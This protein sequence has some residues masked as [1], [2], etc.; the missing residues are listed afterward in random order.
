MAQSSLVFVSG[1]VR[2]GKSSFAE[3][4]AINLAN[5]Q[6]GTLYYIA[7]GR[8]GDPEMQERIAQHKSDRENGAGNWITLEYP[9]AI[10]AAVPL[11]DSNS[12]VLLDCLTTLLNNEMFPSASNMD[13]WE[14][15]AFLASLRKRLLDAIKEISKHAA[16][17][18]VVSN[19]VLHAPVIAKGVNQT[20]SKMI[21]SLHQ[22]MVAMSD[23]AYLME[24]GCAVLMK[25][26]VE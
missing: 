6:N 12:I 21:G 15:P 5:H 16:S 24:A 22:E 19:E 1:G 2:S 14:D 25:G 11:L 23:T 4:L 8:P 13:E 7:C 18:I 17:L 10:E 20:Y 3:Q 26:E 9:V